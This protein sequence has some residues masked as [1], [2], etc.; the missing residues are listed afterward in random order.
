[1]FDD[2]TI[3]WMKAGCA[4]IV[5]IAA[6]VP[7]AWLDMP[8]ASAQAMMRPNL[9]IQPRIPTV[10]PTIAPRVNPNVAARPNTVTGASPTTPSA[11]PTTTSM[12]PRLNPHSTT[13]HLRYSPNLYPSCEAANR[14]AN[15][16]CQ[17][18][19]I[20]SGD[21]G[22]TGKSAKGKGKGKG[23]NSPSTATASLNFP[24]ELVA[25]I[26]GSMSEEQVRALARRHGMVLVESQNL[27]LIG[28][29]IGL[30]RI[31]NGR[32]LD[33][34]RRSFAADGSVRGVQ[35]NMRYFLQQARTTSEGDPAQYA[36]AKL[37]LP[38]AHKLAH[39]MNV[40][41]AVIDSGID[42]SHPELANSIADN[43]DALG[44]KEG[45]HVHGTGIAG[46]IAAHGRLMGSAPEA[47]IIAIRAFASAQGGAES[48]SYVIIKSLNY[49]VL[50]GAQIINMSF[51]GP[52][53]LLIERG[54]AATAARGIVLV[55]A[56]GNAGPKS[57]PLY[58]AANPNVIAV[59]GTDA[60]DRLFAASN[61]G[62][63]IALAAPGTDIFLPAPD[64]KYQMTSGTSFSA[65]YVSGIV[66][67]LL[68]RNP[69]LK[70]N[71]IRA[72]LTATARDLGTPGKDELFGHGQ[73]DAFAAA[74][75]A[76]A[77]P[78]VP[79]ADAPRGP[80]A[81][82]ADNDVSVSRELKAPSAAMASDKSATNE[83]NRPGAQ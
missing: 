32:P 7:L 35:F 47:R 19:P 57:P 42:A 37:K 31:T 12:R 6:S 16:E 65:A 58:P 25:E 62:V 78:A 70:P 53:D 38:Q 20:A 13:P 54:I 83:P 44:S 27:P 5:L 48:S 51:A 8:Q 67:L 28:A 79:M 76:I 77:A 66:A 18:K 24:N 81:G 3:R 14:D 69:A 1:M 59:S 64:Q 45:A 60:K 43:F 21:G 15:G 39:G 50:H 4:A 9:N 10:N 71:E 22:G 17:G 23:P 63:H 55:A 26:D 61:R 82:T 11:A 41:I 56:A 74:T 34:A 46:A 52:K 30:F 2:R 33:A 73:A 72:I 68:E 36:V 29:T 40:T 75:A 49:A 80:G